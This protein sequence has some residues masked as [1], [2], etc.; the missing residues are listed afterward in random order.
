VESHNGMDILGFD[1]RVKLQNMQQQF[2]FHDHDIIILSE[3]IF[4]A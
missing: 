2:L 3:L 1:R 4:R